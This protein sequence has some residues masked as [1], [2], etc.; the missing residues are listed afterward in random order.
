MG[1]AL[2]RVR[3]SLSKSFER[4]QQTCRASQ[5]TLVAKSPPVSGRDAR[6]MAAVPGSGRAPGEGSGNPLQ[7][8][9][10]REEEKERKSRGNY[11]RG[12]GDRTQDRAG[13]IGVR[14]FQDQEGREDRE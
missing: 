3:K 5:A 2:F 4:E 9:Q 13:G 1:K 6:G 7:E 14:G 8:S 12:K 10:D 11:R